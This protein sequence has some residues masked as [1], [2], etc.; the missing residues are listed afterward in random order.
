[1]SHAGEDPPAVPAR[2]VWLVAV[3]CVAEVLGM[4]GNA[5]FP[6][7]IPTFLAEWDLS[8]TEA[9]W[10]S[11]VYYVGYVAAVP[12]LVSLTDRVD[13]W[14]IY[15]GSTAVG[16]VAALGFALFADGLWSAAA[17]RLLGGVGLAGT[18]MVGLRLLSDRVSGS[19]QSRAVAWYTANFSIGTS[20]S[21]LA[22]GEAEALAGWRWSFGAAALGSV[23]ALLLVAAFVRPGPPPKRDGAAGSVF[24]FRPVIRN[25]S[26]MAYVLGYAAHVWELFGYRTWI[27]AFLAFALGSA[28]TGAEVGE[29]LRL[30]GL[31]PTQLA[32]LLMLLGLPASILGNELAIRHGRRRVVTLAMLA[33]GALSCVLGFAVGLPIWL[34][35]PVLAVYGVLIMLDSSALTAGAVAAA[36]PARKGAT[37]ALHTFLG[38]GAGVL[39]PL[40]FGAVLDAAGGEDEA[41]AWWLAF[42]VLG[43]G[44]WLGPLAVRL[45]TRTTSS[46]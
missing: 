11:G 16:G 29:S 13:A 33:S 30:L 14:R 38:F 34:F 3:M 22:A 10:I 25:R 35:L 5:T 26:A 44:V 40:A 4:L 21:V 19:L 8:N 46:R 41:V 17:F 24:D 20:L 31:T 15:L 37:M 36:D 9:G 39:A 12:V 7:L 45:L 27:V 2:G 1:V 42:V 32:T 23:A 28:A 43:L 6:A 18:Y